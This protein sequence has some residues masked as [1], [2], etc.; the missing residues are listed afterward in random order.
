M[1]EGREGLDASRTDASG[2]A[3]SPR[4]RP[5]RFDTLDKLRLDG[6]GPAGSDRDSRGE[7]AGAH[8]SAGP[9]GHV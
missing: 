1:C 8:R 2:G 6:S 7:G 9:E 4:G 3:S 5:R